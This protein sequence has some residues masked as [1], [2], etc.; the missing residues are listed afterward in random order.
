MQILILGLGNPIL[1]DDGIGVLVAESLRPDV[2]DP[3]VEIEELSVGGLTLMERM[4]GY[5]RAILV[6]ALMTGRDAPGTVRRL[7]LE[8]LR[9]MSVTQ[10]SASVHD[11]TL[12]TALD[13]GRRAGMALPAELVI[14]AIEV[15]NVMDFGDAP[16]PAVAAALPV[17]REAVL[18][19]LAAWGVSVG[20]S[21]RSR[22]GSC[23]EEA[24]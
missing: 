16:T 12:V 8:D 22:N 1:T 2:T 17:A 4:V 6:D 10:H 11:A 20:P 18:R 21:D 24:P 9:E 3:S 5:D 15:E 13:V 19:E 23:E 7:T 14:V